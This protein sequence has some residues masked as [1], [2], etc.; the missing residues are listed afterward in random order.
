MFLLLQHHMSVTVPDVDIWD[1]SL[2]VNVSWIF[3]LSCAM[4][5]AFHL[6]VIAKF[7]RCAFCLILYGQV[8]KTVTSCVC[9][10]VCVCVFRCCCLIIDLKV[11]CFPTFLMKLICLSQEVCTN[12]I[13]HLEIPEENMF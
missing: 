1:T 10:C 3:I 8:W 12:Q 13:S 2:A 6:F 7:T 5:S 4:L 11:A 9:V